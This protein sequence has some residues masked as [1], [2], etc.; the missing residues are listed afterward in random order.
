MGLATSGWEILAWIVRAVKSSQKREGMSN[1]RCRLLN[2]N[3][4]IS[5]ERRGNENKQPTCGTSTPAIEERQLSHAKSGDLE[6]RGEISKYFTLWTIVSTTSTETSLNLSNLRKVPYIQVCSSLANHPSSTVLVE[7]L[8]RCHQDYRAPK[9]PSPTAL[10]LRSRTKGR[11]YALVRLNSGGRG[12]RIVRRR[13]L[14]AFGRRRIM[15]V[16][17]IGQDGGN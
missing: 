2:E 17:G 12:R 14:L 6:R 16:V 15:S 8:R 5:K 4:G 13:G 7:K 1:C 10:R 11:H 9:S 3:V